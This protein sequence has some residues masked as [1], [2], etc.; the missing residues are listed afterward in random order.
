MVQLASRD[1]ES[2]LIPVWAANGTH[3]ANTVEDPWR[4]TIQM[5]WS[6]DPDARPLFVF[7]H[8][9]VFQDDADSSVGAL[10]SS[11]QR[12]ANMHAT[13]IIDASVEVTMN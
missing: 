7:L 4:Q 6:T 2:G 5:C 9:H 12:G 1:W 11:P 3:P 10:P 8:T 13:A